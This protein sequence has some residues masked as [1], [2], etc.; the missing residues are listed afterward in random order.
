LRFLSQP[1]EAE[2]AHGYRQ[3]VEAGLFMKRTL[4]ISGCLVLVALLGPSQWA[5]ATLGEPADTINADRTALKAVK[6]ATTTH[7]G[8]TVE[9]VVADAT[10]VREY[11]SPSGIVFGVAWNGYAYPDLTQLLGSYWGEYRDARK[12][13]P[14]VHGRRSQRISTDDVVVETWGRMRDLQGRAY[15]PALIPSGVSIDEIK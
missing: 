8:Y 11:V 1:P 7:A 15:V 10:T 5:R 6:R 2:F 4:I 12:N 9:E 13:A 3:A 14:R